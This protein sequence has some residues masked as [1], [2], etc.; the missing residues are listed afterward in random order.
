MLLRRTHLRVLSANLYLAGLANVEQGTIPKQEQVPVDPHR[1][2]DRLDLDP[3]VRRLT[4][5]LT[6][7][8]QFS[9]SLL[10]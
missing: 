9:S 4:I 5:A 10:I 6:F 2:L 1:L 3:G 7:L 8:S